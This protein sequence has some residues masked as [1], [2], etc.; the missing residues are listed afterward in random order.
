MGLTEKLTDVKSQTDA[1]IEYANETTGQA[2][3]RL[4]D[5]IQSL[6]DGFGQGGGYGRVVAE[7]DFDISEDFYTTG[8]IDI[9]EFKVDGSVYEEYSNEP[10]S[11]FEMKYIISGQDFRVCS[12]SET[13]CKNARNNAILANSNT[14]HIMILNTNQ[15]LVEQWVGLWGGCVN[16]EHGKFRIMARAK[17][18]DSVLDSI[19]KGTYHLIALWT[20]IK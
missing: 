19:K 13:F 6:V 7:L 16:I 5:A 2:D 3:V 12:N 4:G 9:S 17:A 14:V 20:K 8:Q 15:Y 10:E 18:N 11:V 1:L